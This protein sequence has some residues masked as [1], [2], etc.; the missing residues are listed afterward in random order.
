MMD[1]GLII[2]YRLLVRTMHFLERIVADVGTAGSQ[3]S[4]EGYRRQMASGAVWAVA[5]FTISVLVV[6]ATI[7]LF[8]GQ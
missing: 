4:R 7:L 8:S 3:R 2:N 6:A 5:T 1:A